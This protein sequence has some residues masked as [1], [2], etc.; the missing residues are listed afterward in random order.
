MNILT[1]LYIFEPTSR[2]RDIKEWV[3]SNTLVGKCLPYAFARGFLLTNDLVLVGIAL[4]FAITSQVSLGIRVIFELL[5]IGAYALLLVARSTKRYQRVIGMYLIVI[6]AATIMNL[7]FPG[8]WEGDV[9]LYI[10]YV[11]LCYRF[12]LHWA[13]PL[14]IISFFVLIV[15]N[16][17][18]WHLPSQLR[19][20]GINVALVVGLCWLGW[21]RRTQ[22]LLIVRLRE[23]QEQ[24]RQQ[25]ARSEEMAAERE[26]TRIA[27]DIHDV[28]SH[29]LAVLSIQV[30]AARHLRTRDT[31][32]LAAKLDEMAILI[33]ES[34]TESR[35]VVG[36]LREQ[37]TAIQDELST[38][39]QSQVLTFNER[40]GIACSFEEQGTAHEIGTQHREILRLALR[41][42]LTNAHR[43]GAA[44]TIWVT[45]QWHETDVLLEA[46][47]DGAGANEIQKDVAQRK[48]SGHHGLQG[49]RERA[50][51]LGGAINA[52]P[53]ETGGFEVS[54]RLP[55]ALYREGTIKTGSSM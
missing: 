54:I 46:C 52:G 8:I 53:R 51:A 21:T 4:Y 3:W 39:L 12:P 55:Y 2:E 42:M 20:L 29:S 19:D 17:V 49:M 36:L 5:F 22:Y 38:S 23:T 25:M 7:I 40:T 45:L 30:Q 44:K 26:R 33:R 32:R 15:T 48:N 13:L 37:P 50:T 6:G 27:R 1:E 14:T 43:H 16:G 18:L 31:E 35:R 24:L 47:D 28:L 41:E 9:I 11:T 34:I 10:L